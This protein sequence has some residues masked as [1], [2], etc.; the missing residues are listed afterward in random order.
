MK[1]HLR[2]DIFSS[3]W[4]IVSD[5]RSKRPN[6][7]LNSRVTCPFCLGNEKETPPTVLERKNGKK[8]YI[9]V[10]KNKYPALIENNQNIS[11]TDGMFLKY[12][13][14]GRHEVII[15]TSSHNDKIYEIKHLKEVFEVFAIR[16]REFYNTKNVKYV[17]LFRN[18]GINAGASLKHPHSQIISLPLVP[19]R[20]K[21][22]VRKFKEYFKRKNRCLMCDVIKSELNLGRRILYYNKSFVAFAPFASRFNFELWISPIKHSVNFFEYKN[23]DDLA[24]IFRIVFKKIHYVIKGV[25]YNMIFHT[26]PKGCLDFHWHIE[27]LPKLAMPAGFEW[28]SGFYINSISPETAIFI[29]KSEKKF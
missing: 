23:F 12:F 29:L 9:R 20:V 10:V 27:I 6:D 15:E 24:D 19:L 3:S 13:V 16:M 5:E 21:D 8:W 2:K 22:E 14:N 28:G 11:E 18:Y 1:P 25:S 17:M 26:A 4:V 7:Y